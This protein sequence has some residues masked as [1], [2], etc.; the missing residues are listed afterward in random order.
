MGRR[1][2]ARWT[3]T[4][5]NQEASAHR[6]ERTSTGG[7]AMEVR[8]VASEDDVAAALRA[9]LRLLPLLRDPS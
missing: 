4:L 5:C 2:W 7:M 6:L 1:R 3:C 9:L 8:W